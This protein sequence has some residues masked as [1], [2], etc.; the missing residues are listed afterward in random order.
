MIKIKIIS[1]LLL[2]IWTS[3]FSQN[4][5]IIS[6]LKSNSTA[7]DLNEVN[8]QFDKDFYNN[9][10]FFFGYVHGSEIPQKLDIELLKALNKNGVSYYAPEIDFSL[11]YFFNEYL[12][13]GNESILNFACNQYKN[14]VSQDASIQFKNKW[15]AIYEFNNLLPEDEKITVLGLDKE[16]S[17]DL[18]LTHIA[19]ISP[20]TLTG[21]SI[22]DSLKFFKNLNIREINIIS[23]KPVFKSGKSW[24][25]FFGT[26]KTAFLKRFV[27]EYKKDSLSILKV[28]GE[29]SD[30]LK[31]LMNPPITKNREHTI[32][33]NFKKKGYPLIAENQ[34]IYFNYGYFHVHQK[35]INGVMPIAGLIKQDKEIDVISIVGMLTESE[36]LKRRR[37]KYTE[38]IIIKGV[39]FK[40]SSYNDYS[41]S[42]TWDGDHL[43]ERV[44]G[45]KLLK[46]ISKDN[47][48]ML[49]KLN[50]A[51]SPLFS[52]ML[53]ANFSR[54]GKK[55]KVE[56]NAVTN[57]YFQYILLIKNSKPNV[58]LEEENDL[59]TTKYSD[60]RYR[61]LGT[62]RLN[63]NTAQY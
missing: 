24:D 62:G 25:Y 63:L 12:I 13:S 47:Q 11:A 8:F 52:K 53:F 9:D 39:K 34:K 21:I 16:T 55:W 32:Y 54:G 4:D 3:S 22:V 29:K 20:D 28:F 40:G 2:G 60:C 45:I 5:S 50:G 57:D 44:N 27:A 35:T 48:I 51:N 30:D 17:K 41:T 23:G 58:P 42:K 6:Y 7:I 26:E 49:F 14:H 56:Q 46:K 59:L 10:I 31:H 38:P 43:F 18:T 36:C 1:V 61:K 19:F 15:K 37:L 33:A